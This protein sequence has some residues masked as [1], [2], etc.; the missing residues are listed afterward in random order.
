MAQSLIYCL[1]IVV[2]P[3]HW[4]MLYFLN[5]VIW[6]NHWSTIYCLST[7]IWLN[8]WSMLYF[9][10]TVMYGSI[11]DLIRN[12]SP[13]LPCQIWLSSC[14]MVSYLSRWCWWGM[15]EYFTSCVLRSTRDVGW[16]LRCTSFRDVA[17][18]PKALCGHTDTHNTS[19]PK[20]A[21]CP[22]RHTKSYIQ[23]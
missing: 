23:P 13:F 2:W 16:W 20:G 1:S 9:L 11:T 15:A 12:V 10:S 18:A 4:S 5:T 17:R 21:L 14:L 3:N 8:H 19:S 22:H 6:L 7:V